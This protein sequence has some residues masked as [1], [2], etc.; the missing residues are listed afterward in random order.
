MAYETPITIRKAVLAMQKQ[1]YVLPAIQ[2]EYVWK[3]HQITML[4]DSLMRDYPISTFLFWK[5]EKSQ[6]ADFQFYSF[7]REYHQK[8]ARHNPKVHL[9][10]DEDVIAI[11]DGQQRLTSIFIGLLGTYAEK[12][13]YLRWNSPKAFPKKK[14][15]LNIFSPSEQVGVEYDFQ[16][17]TSEEAK[18]NDKNTYWFEVGLILDLEGTNLYRYLKN[19]SL[20]DTSK[21]SQE[22]TDFAFETLGTLQNVIH[23]KGAISYYLEESKELDK[24]LQIFIRVNSGGTKLSYSDLLLSIA[25]AQWSELDAREVI[26]GFV[27]EL[28][29]IGDGFAFNK[30]FILKSCLVLADFSDIR[31]K[32]DNFTKQNMLKIENIWDDISSALRLAVRLVS[33]FGFSRDNLKA[34]TAIIP[35]AYFILKNGNSDKI[36]SST[37]H[38]EDRINIR[39]WLIRVLLKGTFGGQPDSIYPV[40]R[41]MINDNVGKFPLQEIIEHYAGRRKSISFVYD[42]VLSLLDIEYGRANSYTALSLLYPGINGTMRFHQDHIFPKSLFNHKKLIEKGFSDF[43]QREKMIRCHNKIGNLQLLQATT[44]IEK[45][46]LEFQ[47]WLSKHFLNE[48]EI[49]SF[50]QRHHIPLGAPRELG[51]FLEFMDERKKNL[52]KVFCNVLGVE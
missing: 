32:V 30:D 11:L 5:V 21:Y 18:E 14:L 8:D 44:N 15:Y 13:P 46:N 26:H 43:E 3:P 9:V 7:L 31:F 40:M 19:N 52:I 12:V 36:L 51:K 10:G 39:K 45:S 35:I 2:R 27:D 37:H 25:T 28:N 1:Q 34:S 22:Q 29:V 48:V 24:V 47:D 49:A 50:L 16:F 38:R 17:L 23:Q 4:F 42:D 6:V 20:M 41:K 33:Q